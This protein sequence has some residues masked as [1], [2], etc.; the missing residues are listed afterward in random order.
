MV[1]NYGSYIIYLFISIVDSYY[2]WFIIP[3]TATGWGLRDH[4]AGLFGR[5]S[6]VERW[7]GMKSALPR[8]D[9]DIGC[10]L[11]WGS[12]NHW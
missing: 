6:R 12:Q 1:K 8:S 10:S 7:G 9:A 4:W 5:W 2:S 11:K 3:I